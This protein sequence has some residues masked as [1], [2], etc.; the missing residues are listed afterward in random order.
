MDTRL[1]RRNPINEQPEFS[2]PGA[3]WLV[4]GYDTV[5]ASSIRGLR[6]MPMKE[7]RDQVYRYPR[8]AWKWCCTLIRNNTLW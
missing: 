6:S 5:V 1:L 7:L 8:P 4:D 2:E 3:Q